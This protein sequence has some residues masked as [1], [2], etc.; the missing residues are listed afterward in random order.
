MQ[1]Q[2]RLRRLSAQI[3]FQQ[4]LNDASRNPTS[5]WHPLSHSLGHQLVGQR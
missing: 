3:E 1:L 5:E 2:P 4:R